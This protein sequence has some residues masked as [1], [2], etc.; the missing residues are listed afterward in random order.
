M[1]TQLKPGPHHP[2]TI[3]PLG[4]RVTVKVGGRIVAQS[5][6]ALQLREASYPPAICRTPLTVLTKVRRRTTAYRSAGSVRTMRSGRTNR[7]T[8]LFPVSR[9][10][11]RFI[12]TRSTAFPERRFDRAPSPFAQRGSAP[13]ARSKG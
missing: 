11:S 2:I 9:I 10:A 8:T 12:P 6:D 7:P 4:R 3:E 5:D 13:R 1:R